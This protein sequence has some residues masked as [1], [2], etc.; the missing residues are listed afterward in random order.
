MSHIFTCT[1]IM[2]NLVTWVLL[3]PFTDLI[4][5]AHLTLR[6]LSNPLLLNVWPGDQ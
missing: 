4:N 5:K 2:Q 3:N 6:N 1:H